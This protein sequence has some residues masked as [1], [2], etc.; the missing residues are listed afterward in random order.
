MER[1]QS[2]DPP[3]L[4][5]LTNLQVRHAT[6]WTR[7]GRV[8]HQCSARDCKHHLLDDA[9]VLLDLLHHLRPWMKGGRRPAAVC[10]WLMREGAK[11]R[12]RVPCQ[13]TARI[14]TAHR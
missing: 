5:N 7:G 1:K 11:E 14:T 10:V 3:H 12:A 2:A 4:P 6:P 13:A 9:A 8:R